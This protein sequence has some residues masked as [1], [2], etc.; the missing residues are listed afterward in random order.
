VK[1]FNFN[2]VEIGIAMVVASMA[3]IALCG[4]TAVVFEKKVQ[5][6][7]IVEQKAD[8]KFSPV[9]EFSDTQATT[10]TTTKTTQQKQSP[11]LKTVQEI[12]DN[13]WYKLKGTKEPAF[14]ER[15]IVKDVIYEDYIR[16]HYYITNKGWG[17]IHA[18]HCPCFSNDAEIKELR[19]MLENNK[20]LIKELEGMQ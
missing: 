13:S 9:E 10:V 8:P 19:D 16:G 14:C 5:V 11:T 2:L 15:A 7:K 4:L 3:L 17:M 20:K 18:A 12:F 1:Q 6:V